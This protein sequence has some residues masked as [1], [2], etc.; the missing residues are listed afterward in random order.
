MNYQD[1]ARCFGILDRRSQAY[2][3]SSCAH[4][5]IGFSEYSLLLKLYVNEGCHQEELASLMAADKAWVARTVKALEE[6]NLIRRVQDQEDRRLKRIYITEYGHSLRDPLFAVLERWI[7]RLAEGMEEGLVQQVLRGLSI[8]AEAASRLDI[9]EI[10]E[11][12][13]KDG[14]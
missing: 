2:I 7:D 6:K 3:I 14:I 1:A 9:R 8:A 4:W 10:T 12:E 11:R 5:N 13:R